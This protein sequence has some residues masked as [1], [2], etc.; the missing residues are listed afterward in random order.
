[1]LVSHRKRFI[2]TKTLKTAGTSVESY[3]EK[4]CLPRGQWQFSHAR[5][6]SVRKEGIIGYRGRGKKD[7]AWYNHMP[8]RQIK[9]QLGDQLW[10]DYFKFCVIRNPFDKLLS[11]FY[12]IIR[13]EMIDP[14]LLQAD[15]VASFRNWLKSGGRVIDRDKY[16]IEGRVCLDYFIRYENLQEGIREVCTRLQVPFEPDQVPRLKTGMRN[17]QIPLKD[18][19]DAQSISIVKDLYSFE[20]D[21]FGYDF[22]S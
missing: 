20:L 17:D 19:Y 11:H 9:E 4:Y 22:P 12:Y 5:E 10:E 1:M 18:Y 2:Y 21:Y 15:D 7:P 14:R 13:K 8:A 16:L 3:F 6:A